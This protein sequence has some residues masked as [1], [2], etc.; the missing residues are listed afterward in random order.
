MVRDMREFNK[1]Q[2]VFNTPNNCVF[3]DTIKRMMQEH[4]I[5]AVKTCVLKNRNN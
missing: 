1:F 5:K 4:N 2:G 3:S